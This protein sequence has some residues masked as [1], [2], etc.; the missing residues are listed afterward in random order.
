MAWF[1][2]SNVAEIPSPS[3]LV[4]PDRIEENIRRMV[5]MVGGE[6]GRLRPHMKT[7][8]MPEVIRLHLKHGITKFK[9]ATIAEAEM[10]ADAGALEV[11]LAYPPVGPN[12]G[13]FLALMRKFPGTKFAAVV[14]G[15]DSARALSSAASAAG[16]VVATYIDIDCGMHRTG[17]APDEGAVE[18][19]QLLAA[20]PGLE[21]AGI[22]A[23]DG[24]IHDQD[25]A[26]RTQAVESSFAAVEAFRD[27]LLKL[28]LPMPHYIASGTPTFGIHAK[29]GGYECS[30]GTCVLWD[31]GYGT[32]HPD[33]DFLHA[34]L[35]LTRV[36]SKPSGGRLTCDLGHKS[37]AAE[38]PHPRVH[39]LNLPDARAVM[40][41]EEHLVL[42][43]P[44]AAEFKV[45]DALYGVPWHICPT[46]ALHAY[47]NVV[48]DG[49]VV[50]QW[51][52]AGRERIISL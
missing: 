33:L 10:T 44:R 21:A 12:V 32:K 38:N 7:H 22:H 13:R 8:K 28:A 9:C 37:V 26:V 27:R 31:W 23:Y 1:E 5:A 18:L 52:V 3:L 41:S 45:G 51:R 34:A 17:I 6:A 50:G 46:V 40:H 15:E 14:D 36:I 25:L 30:P 19:Y 35:V 20:L 4:Y 43:T 24:H 42:E 16:M 29:R 2:I 48:R 47:A 39:F 49:R 11:L